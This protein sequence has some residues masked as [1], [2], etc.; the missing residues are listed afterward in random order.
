[1]LPPTDH[2]TV[3]R[4]R[5]SIGEHRRKYKER[6]LRGRELGRIG[7]SRTLKNTASVRGAIAKVAHLV[8]VEGYRP[9][10][11]RSR[12]GRPRPTRGRRTYIWEQDLGP[13]LSWD[14]DQ[15]VNPGLLRC[16]TPANVTAHA[17]SAEYASVPAFVQ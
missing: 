13:E 10:E 12:R 11:T 6:C 8:Q 5:S 17:R 16:H 15:R 7:A 14:E 4:T 2:I 1:M 3:T 9:V